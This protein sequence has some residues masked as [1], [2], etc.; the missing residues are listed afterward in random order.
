MEPDQSEGLRAAP[1]KQSVLSWIAVV[2]MQE[3]RSQTGN[4]S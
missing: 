4:C 2:G 3:A 1:A